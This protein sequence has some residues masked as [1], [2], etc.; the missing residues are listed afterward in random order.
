MLKLKLYL[1]KTKLQLL[2]NEVAIAENEVEVF[3]SAEPL[4]KNQPSQAQVDLDRSSPCGNTMTNIRG[5]A[6]FIKK[7]FLA[8]GLF[9]EAE[10]CLYSYKRAQ[11]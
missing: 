7:T 6:P 8:R 2:K 9:S 1:L 11:A 3:L 4:H 10:I 5:F